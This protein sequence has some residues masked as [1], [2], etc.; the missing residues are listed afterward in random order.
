MLLALDLSTKST[1]FAIFNIET[2]EL[3]AYG[4]LVEKNTNVLNRIPSMENKIIDL[5]KKYKITKVV[6]EEVLMNETLKDSCYGNQKTLK[7]LLYLQGA[8]SIRVFKDYKLEIEYIQANVWR[9]IIGIKVGRGIKRETL[10]KE[11]IRFAA[12]TYS[13]DQASL[14]DDEADAIC[15]GHAYLH[16]TE[17]KISAW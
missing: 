6:A 16:K 3:I 7:A 2:K 5:F 15:I 14:T 8:I 9:S 13:L 17:K 11:D 10:K 4:C 1:G 12:Q